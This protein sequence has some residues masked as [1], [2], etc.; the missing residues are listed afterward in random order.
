[1]GGEG[2]GAGVEQVD[3]EVCILWDGWQGARGAQSDGTHWDFEVCSWWE[4]Q[5]PVVVVDC[6]GNK[7]C[8]S[9]KQV[10]AGLVLSS[11]RSETSLREPQ[12]WGIMGGPVTTCWS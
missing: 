10:I 1:M 11:L 5:K 12:D 9:D 2:E 3:F 8:T 6:L 4:R 7:Y